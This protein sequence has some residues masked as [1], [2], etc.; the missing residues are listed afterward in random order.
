M[1][2]CGGK[3]L[4]SLRLLIFSLRFSEESF[5]RSGLPGEEVK[6]LKVLFNTEILE[7]RQRNCQGLGT[8]R[9]FVLSQDIRTTSGERRGAESVVLRRPVARSSYY[10]C[11][12]LILQFWKK[13]TETGL[14]LICSFCKMWIQV[15]IWMHHISPPCVYA[16]ALNSI[17]RLPL[18]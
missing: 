1:P 15:L 8:G 17:G 16:D 10:K 2:G 9:I 11:R 3:I 13:F 6:T 7:R 4:Q 14:M 18:L 12:W 5:W